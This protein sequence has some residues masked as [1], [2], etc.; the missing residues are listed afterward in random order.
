MSFLHKDISIFQTSKEYDTL[1][2]CLCFSDPL[3]SNNL[4]HRTWCSPLTITNKFDIYVL[5]LTGLTKS[6]REA[7]GFIV[8]AADVMDE[9][10][11]LQVCLQ[12]MYRSEF[13][14][15][16]VYLCIYLFFLL[17]HIMWAW[18][19]LVYNKICDSV[20]ILLFFL[21]INY[22]TGSSWLLRT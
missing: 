1:I 8:K 6:D 14:H 19:P 12:Y 9:L 10:F 22:C 2:G 11:Y 3:T 20:F 18:S 4:F 15:L 16:F 5:Q 13:M 7:L 21:F 17:S